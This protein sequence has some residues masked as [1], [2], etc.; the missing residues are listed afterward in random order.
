MRA[1]AAKIEITPDRPVF[2]DGRDPVYQRAGVDR[3]YQDAWE[4][5]LSFEWMALTYGVS[6]VIDRNDGPLTPKGEKTRRDRLLPRQRWALVF[7]GPDA[8]VYLR[9]SPEARGFIEAHEYRLI[10]PERRADHVD[11]PAS[12]AG[13]VE[14]LRGEIE[15]LLAQAPRV[16]EAWVLLGRL[17]QVA[18]GDPDGA[19]EAFDEA[20][21]I[22]PRIPLP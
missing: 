6:L 3:I 2:I 19:R 7:H 13:E 18:D 11:G 16:A 14:A 15:R 4:D 10:S 1:G 8:S 5:P 12:A 21:A 17:R 9:R 20:Q 22:D